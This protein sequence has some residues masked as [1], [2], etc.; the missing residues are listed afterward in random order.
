MILKCR[1][2]LRASEVKQTLQVDYDGSTG[3]LRRSDADGAAGGA[4]N[5]KSHDRLV[6]R[7]DLLNIKRSVG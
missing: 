4:F 6:N 7:A 1:G 2:A 5:L 3:I